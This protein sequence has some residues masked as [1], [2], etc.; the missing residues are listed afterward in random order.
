VANL[1]KTIWKRP[2]KK[3]VMT[4]MLCERVSSKKLNCIM[5]VD[6]QKMICELYTAK[7]TGPGWYVAKK[8]SKW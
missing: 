1:A 7:D 4:E 6:G 8:C 5:R 2:P 3:I